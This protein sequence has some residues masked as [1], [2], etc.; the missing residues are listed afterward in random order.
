MRIRYQADAD[1]N[2]KI[3]TATTRLDSR[4]DFRTAQ[5]ADLAVKSDP[6]VLK[7]AAWEGRILVTHDK[8]TM[9]DHLTRFIVTQESPGVFIV[10]RGRRLMEVAEELVL[11]WVASDSEEWTNRIVYIPL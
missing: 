3:V 5:A 7:T 10:P 6:E 4:V 1:L 8:S 2:Q 9:P 11:V